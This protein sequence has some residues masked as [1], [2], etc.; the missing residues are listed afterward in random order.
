MIFRV[1]MAPN[2]RILESRIG[3]VSSIWWFWF[4]AFG[5]VYLPNLTFGARW[6]VSATWSPNLRVCLI[7]FRCWRHI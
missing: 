3:L 2:I 4:G 1:I 5:G 6:R 7:H